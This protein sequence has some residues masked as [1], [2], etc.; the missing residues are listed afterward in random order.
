MKLY[1]AGFEPGYDNG[2]HYVDVTFVARLSLEDFHKLSESVE[3]WGVSVEVV[4]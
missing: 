1:V 2:S 4:K 3:E